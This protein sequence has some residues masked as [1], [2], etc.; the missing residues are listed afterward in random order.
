MVYEQVCVSMNLKQF[1]AS[2][3]YDV[4]LMHYDEHRPSLENSC[5]LFSVA[6]E[7]TLEKF[8]KK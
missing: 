2:F 5:I 3:I 1:S 8:E 7:E 4:V 6:V